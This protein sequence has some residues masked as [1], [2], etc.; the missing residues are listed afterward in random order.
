MNLPPTTTKRSRD[1][2]HRVPDSIVDTDATSQTVEPTFPWRALETPLAGDGSPIAPTR[3][4]FIDESDAEIASAIVSP[5]EATPFQAASGLTDDSLGNSVLISDVVCATGGDSNGATPAILYLALRRARIWGRATVIGLID[6]SAP[7]ADLLRLE[8]LEDVG[9]AGTP[10]I[11]GA[12]RLDLAIDGCWQ[13]ADKK[14]R[15]TLR[16][17]FVDEAVETLERW[18]KQFFTSKWFQTL[19]A[20]RLTREQYI[21]TLSNLHQFVRWTTRLIGRA[22]A[23]SHDRELRNHWLHHLQDEINHELIIEKDLK[24]L[25]ADPQYVVERMPPHPWTLQFMGLQESLI[26]FH[27]DP[28]LFMAS[29]FVAEGYGARLDK[30]FLD[31]L[32]ASARRWGVSNPKLVTSFYSSHINYDGGDDGHWALTRNILNRCLIDDAHLQRFLTI[33]R[34]AADATERGYTAYVSDLVV[35][36]RSRRTRSDA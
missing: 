34:A 22:V 35:F 20:D 6:D 31:A 15:A 2:S 12:Q 28:V 21:L 11:V 36:E 3:V 19:Y 4:S 5:A 26:G 10:L 25:G 8:R 13:S 29:P 24:N 30:H 33:V 14:T 9:I 16:T 23:H 27:G 17:L 7:E 18:V 1:P 32:E